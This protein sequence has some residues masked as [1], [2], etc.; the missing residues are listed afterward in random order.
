MYKKRGDKGIVILLVPYATVMEA[1]LLATE[2]AIREGAD[3]GEHIGSDS[4][5]VLKVSLNMTTKANSTCNCHNTLQTLN[6]ERAFE[7]LWIHENN[8][9]R[10]QR[11]GDS[12]LPCNAGC[13][14]VTNRFRISCRNILNTD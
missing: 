3:S 8:I 13:G 12:T 6:K 4:M 9:I 1:K 5:V 11:Q 10:D 2:V 14:V 7:L